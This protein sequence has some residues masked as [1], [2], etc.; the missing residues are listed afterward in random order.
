MM[1]RFYRY[2]TKMLEHILDPP[3]SVVVL[4]GDFKTY[5]EYDQSKDNDRVIE[6]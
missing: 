4:K 5:L 3:L 1:S 2:S 6:I